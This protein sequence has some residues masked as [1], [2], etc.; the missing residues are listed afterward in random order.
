[1]TLKLMAALKTKVFTA[2]D[3][4]II[5]FVLTLVLFLLGAG[6]P[7]DHGGLAGG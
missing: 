7:S 3:I 5:L 4:R 1:M 2:N 6:A